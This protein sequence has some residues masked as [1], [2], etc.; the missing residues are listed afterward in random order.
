[1][2]QILTLQLVFSKSKL[3]NWE[4]RFIQISVF[5]NEICYTFE[6]GNL[7]ST[8]PSKHP[9]EIIF[10]KS[11]LVKLKSLKR[12]KIRSEAS[13]NQIK[14]RSRSNSTFHSQHNCYLSMFIE[15]INLCQTLT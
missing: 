4:P 10:M 14:G 2:N 12:L 3:L 1:M 5:G 11:D 13:K 15:N 9:P 8:E 7:E 6:L